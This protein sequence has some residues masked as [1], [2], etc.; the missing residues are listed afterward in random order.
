MSEKPM[1]SARMTMMLGRSGAARSDGAARS[2]GSSARRKRLRFMRG[3]VRLF[4]RFRQQP[5]RRDFIRLHAVDQPVQEPR[6]HLLFHG[7]GLGAAREIG[8]LAW[9][10]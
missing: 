6:A 3:N 7:V 2:A 8:P 10:G 9:I 5:A 1:S 4:V